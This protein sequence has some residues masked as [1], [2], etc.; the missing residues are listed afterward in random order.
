MP[1]DSTFIAR[2]T[3]SYD[4]KIAAVIGSFVKY[5]QRVVKQNRK[6]ISGDY[7]TLDIALFV[8]YFSHV[9][10]IPQ[11]LNPLSVR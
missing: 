6:A 1:E 4:F 5:P 8:C 2:Y 11:W 3:I 10:E 7:G 9:D